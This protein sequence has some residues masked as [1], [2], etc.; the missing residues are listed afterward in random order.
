MYMHIIPL[1]LYVY[2]YIYIYMN[3][4]TPAAG[5]CGG[6]SRPPGIGRRS[7]PEGGSRDRHGR[8]SRRGRF[9]RIRCGE[10]SPGSG[11]FEL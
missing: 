7:P 11:A 1:S 6:D 3:M 4:Q 10:T 2:I 9:P 8:F 5:P